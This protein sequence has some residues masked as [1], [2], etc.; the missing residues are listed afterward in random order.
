[1]AGYLSNLIGRRNLRR[2]ERAASAVDSLDPKRLRAL[3]AEARALSRQVEKVLRSAEGRLAVNLT[4]SPTV[5]RPI[6]SDWGW[7]PEIWRVPTRT[8]A[9]A[10]MASGSPIGGEAKLF[11]D[12]PEGE[13]AVRQV[14]NFR[15]DDTAPFGLRLEVFGFAGNFLSLAIDL[16]PDA[17][18]SLS[19]R[20]V[21]R[22]EAHLETERPVS[23]FARL[24]LRR[25]PNLASQAAILSG[26]EGFLS[27][28][29]DLS[30]TEHGDHAPDHC[31]VDLI[32]DAPEMNA[33][34]LRDLTMSRRPRAE[35]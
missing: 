2:W 14:R 10:G 13:F 3:K 27:G 7:R 20:H 1:M 6:Q 9:G 15:S 16:P 35:L 34:L 32:F 17:V 29:I 5:R 18:A 33:L 28:E 23:V 12:C 4:T 25:G 22:I 11:H 24:N 31:W 8:A 21:F 19:A 26:E 30:S